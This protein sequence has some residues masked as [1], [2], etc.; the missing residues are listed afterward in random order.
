MHPPTLDYCL[1]DWVIRIGSDS[2]EERWRHS[3]PLH[4]HGRESGQSDV[5]GLFFRG[6]GP[7][8]DDDHYFRYQISE[9]K[10]LRS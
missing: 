1:L 3:H 10:L 2:L 8:D 7:C 6:V 5:N 4:D 9:L